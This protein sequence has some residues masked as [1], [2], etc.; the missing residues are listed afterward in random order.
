MA[1][2]DLHLH[3]E[4]S[5]DSISHLA[6]VA[7]RAQRAG[8]THL[9]VTDHNTIAGALRLKELQ[10]LPVIVGEEIMTA[11]GELIGLFLSAPVPPGLSPRQTA[12]LIHQQG[13]LVYVPH[14]MDPYRHGLRAEGLR[15]LADA[16]DVIEV[17]NAR[18][19]RAS[20]NLMA[21]QA[22][23]A[24]PAARAA[25]SDAHTLWEIGRS[26]TEGPDFSDAPGLL[27]SLRA[28]RLRR[29]RSPAAVHLL[30]RYAALRHH[31]PSARP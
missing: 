19:L 9:S 23:E 13:G 27:R 10:G 5:P 3:T 6:A 4:Y 31:R 28:G 11:R 22:A 12:E 26:F 21:A 29:R 7:R 16:I 14:P 30:S 20:S 1:R 2:V 17:F 18:C 24:L 25:A 15:E 8:L